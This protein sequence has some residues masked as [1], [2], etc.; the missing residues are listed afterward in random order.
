MG[1]VGVR[2]ASGERCELFRFKLGN[3]VGRHVDD[4]F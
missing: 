4:P 1:E 2:A 3:N